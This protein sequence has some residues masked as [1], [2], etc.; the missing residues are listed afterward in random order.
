M[1]FLTP[2]AQGISYTYIAAIVLVVLLLK[3]NMKLRTSGLLPMSVI[4]LIEL[5]SAFRGSFSFVD[6]LRFAGVFFI[7]F[8]RMIDTGNEYD[9]AGIIKMYLA[10]YIV[11]MVDIFGQMLKRYSW[12]SILSL[13]VR[14]G[15]TRQ[16]LDIREEGMLLT[17]NPNELGT[18][19]TLAVLFSLLLYKKEK[20]PWYPL[21]IL[22][23]SL[24]GIT[25][26]SR[27]FV[28]VYVL[29]ILLYVCFSMHTLKSALKTIVGFTV[30][31]GVIIALANR[32]LPGY[33]SGI[34]DRFAVSDVSNGRIDIMQYYF[35]EMFKHIDR[36]I[37]GVGLQNYKVKY[38]YFASSHNATQEILITWGILGLITVI[39]LLTVILIHAKK[40]NPQALPIQYIPLFSFL[41]DIQSGQGFS[42]TSGMLCLMVAYSAI[43]I[44]LKSESGAADGASAIHNT[45]KLNSLGEH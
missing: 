38:N 7:A 15:D 26:Q 10:G 39:F 37:F 28:I 25:T 4:L 40:M 44:P 16:L 23:A 29:A 3:Q 19:C 35:N 13:G 34:F 22:I 31:G 5:L 43:L 18:I 21:L 41:I 33:I 9:N 45:G 12:I 36:F 30:G 11:A 14:M 8:L 20:R 24:I 17:F 1:A 42:N 32:L 27:S 2:L 6:Y